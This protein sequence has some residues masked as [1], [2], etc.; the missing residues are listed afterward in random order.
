MHSYVIMC[1]LRFEWKWCRGGCGGKWVGFY[2]KPR[3]GIWG[4]VICT[5][6]FII[7]SLYSWIC[8][9]TFSLRCNSNATSLKS[10]VVFLSSVNSQAF[11]PL[12]SQHELSLFVFLCP[13]PSTLSF[14]SVCWCLKARTLLLCSLPPPPTKCLDGRCSINI[15]WIQWKETPES[16]NDIFNKTQQL[17]A[18]PTTHRGVTLRQ[19]DLFICGETEAGEEP[20][21]AESL[22][23]GFFCDHS[24]ALTIHPHQSGLLPW[25]PFRWLCCRGCLW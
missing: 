9:N 12:Q 20:G 4:W 19:G 23:W 3:V 18:H 10:K 6:E 22:G 15:Y 7:H 13:L 16:I 8:L 25:S 5:W 21:Q 2:M 24:N 14:S 11:F 17:S 1:F